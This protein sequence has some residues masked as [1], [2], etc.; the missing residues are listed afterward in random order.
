MPSERILARRKLL[1]L[2]ILAVFILGATVPLVQVAPAISVLSTTGGSTSGTPTLTARLAIAAGSRALN[3]TALFI[4][5]T[6][7]GA[8]PGIDV[9]EDP[10]YPVVG[11]IG[12]IY[13]VFDHLGPALRDRGYGG[14]IDVVNAI[15]LVAILRSNDT[16]VV[17]MP[18]SVIP[19]AV[20]S[21][22]TNL[23]T[24]WLDRGGVLVWTGDLIG[25]YIG[26]PGETRITWNASQNLQWAGEQRIFGSP[27]VAAAQPFPG[28]ATVATPIATWLDL[29]YPLDFV[30]AHVRLAVDRGGF[31][32][33]FMSADVD[34]STSIAWVPVGRGGVILFGYMPVLPFGYSSEDVIASD[35][36]QIVMS[37][38]YRWN[39][40]AAPGLFTI[41][42][43]AGETR[44]LNITAIL[45]PNTADA[46]LYVYS[47]GPLPPV[48]FSTDFRLP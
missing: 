6:Q 25:G 4:P 27:V 35:I 46:R 37:G 47:T 8:I 42:V 24:P 44:V 20:L 17:V 11:S 1:A 9:Y 19:D 15:D 12:D 10:A 33:G 45:P 39:A 5:L 32:M 7:S 2:G 29:R 16:P 43:G 3:M 18:S 31:P 34:P 23:L 40:A 36:A 28:T 26:L 13:G 14:P 38:I 21:N 30:G 22:A 41:A 48:T